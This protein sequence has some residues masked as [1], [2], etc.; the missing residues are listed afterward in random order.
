VDYSLEATYY[1]TALL[2]GLIRGEVVHRWAEQAIEREPEP[3]PELIEIVSAPSTD[4]SALRHALWPLVIEPV[5]RVV[6]E[7]LF[8]LMHA[9]LASGRRGVTDTLTV[10]RQMRSMLRLPPPMY[11]E[12]NS[13][14]VA[15]ADGRKTAIAEWLEQFAQS[16]SWSSVADRGGAC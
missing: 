5:P 6:F 2:L 1:R 13:V 12:L 11:A 7:A 9:D 16:A 8:G 3:L 15:Y 10:L 14:L 4:L